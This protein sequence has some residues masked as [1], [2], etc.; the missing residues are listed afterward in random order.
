MR[1]DEHLVVE[2]L[3]ALVDD[4]DGG[5]AVQPLLHP[6]EQ[7]HHRRGAG[8]G[9]VQHLGHVEAEGAL[10]EIQLVG[11]VVEQ[12]RV[13]A[14]AVPGGQPALQ[15]RW[16]SGGALPRNSSARWRRRRYSTG[17]AKLASTASTMRA[18]SSG[19]ELAV[20]SVPSALA[21]RATQSARKRRLAG[22]VG[23]PQRVQPAR[24]RPAAARR[25]DRRWR[26]GRSPRPGPCRSTGFE[27][28]SCGP[29]PAG[30][31]APPSCPS[32][33]AR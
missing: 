22:L 27:A 14:A 23:Q 15:G 30:S 21:S 26:A 19:V 9:V 20:R 10:V 33:T 6:V 29:G 5:L 7:I 2:R 4:D 1:C 11:G 25:S 24:L 13:V 16:R 32:P 17:W 28:R 3:P 12:P 18:R 31:P 8:G